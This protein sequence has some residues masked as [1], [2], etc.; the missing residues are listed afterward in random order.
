MKNNII[1]ISI[2]NLTNEKISNVSL[3]DL[4]YKS[5]EN[6]K[7]SSFHNLVYDLILERIHK[8]NNKKTIYLNELKLSCSEGANPNKQVLSPI[9]VETTN[10]FGASCQMTHRP[11]DEKI[12][13]RNLKNCFLHP[14]NLKIDDGNF[15]D[16]RIAEL[17]P[18]SKINFYISTAKYLK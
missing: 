9:T 12:D 10:V 11:D 17:L 4:N 16:I 18:N 6:I 2:E 8:G 14:L 3:F 1:F 5:N 15:L 13:N 7:Y